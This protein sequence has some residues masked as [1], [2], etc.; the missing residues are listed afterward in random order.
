M[1]K[2]LSNRQLKVG[3]LIKHALSEIFISKKLYF[4][5]IKGASITV[6]EV[7]MTADL[8]TATAYVIPLAMKVDIK[9]FLDELENNIYNIRAMV[10]K[11]IN[12]KYS[13]KIIFKFDD[14]FDTAQKLETIINSLKI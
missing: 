14:S 10:T 6:T 4:N 13:P 11:A 8:K 2:P 9:A 1:Q 12:I 5:V 3:E 7:R